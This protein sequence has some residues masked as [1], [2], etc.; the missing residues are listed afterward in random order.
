M[1]VWSHPALLQK[2]PILTHLSFDLPNEPTVPYVAREGSGQLGPHVCGQ[3]SKP[4]EIYSAFSRAQASPA[5]FPDVFYPVVM[6]VD[7]PSCV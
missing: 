3:A 5:L 2:E 1:Y 6:S 7:A 4:F